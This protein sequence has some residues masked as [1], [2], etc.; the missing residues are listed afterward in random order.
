MLVGES[1]LVSRWFASGIK[2]VAFVYL[3]DGNVGQVSSKSTV[4]ST[5]LC[6]MPARTRRIKSRSVNVSNHYLWFLRIRTSL[7]NTTIVLLRCYSQSSFLGLTVKD[8]SR[9]HKGVL[10]CSFGFVIIETVRRESDRFH[11]GAI[12][13]TLLGASSWAMG[14]DC[15]PTATRIPTTS[16]PC[17]I[18]NED[19]CPNDTF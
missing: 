18:V 9:E 16:I 5:L 4:V 19:V 17:R 7:V 14:I 2:S 3:G 12:N 10:R 15:F 13:S 8:N 1:S 6:V 11:W